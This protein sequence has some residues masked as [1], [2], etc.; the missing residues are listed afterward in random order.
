MPKLVIYHNGE[1]SKCKETTELLQDKGYEIEYR[2]YLFEPP[3]K[4]ELLDV[5]NK[6]GMQ[7]SQLVRVSEPLFVEKYDGK[8]LTEDE[9]LQAILEHPVLMQRP[10]V[11]NGDKAIIARP[12]ET[13]LD[14]L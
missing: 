12:P 10:I 7:P 8:G 5:L 2:F 9:W 1:C 13:V 11:V 4:E 14:I 6:L 3:S